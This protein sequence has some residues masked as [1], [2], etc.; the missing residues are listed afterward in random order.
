MDRMPDGRPVEHIGDGVYA[1]YDGIGFW[2]YAND[3]LN[4]TDKV[5]LEPS[6]MEAFDRWRKFCDTLKSSELTERDEPQ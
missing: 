4:P 5:Y 1:I 2:L 3:H 6:V